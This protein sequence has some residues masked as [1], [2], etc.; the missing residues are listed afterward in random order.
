M[1]NPNGLF[2]VEACQIVR[3][4]AMSDRLS[5]VC[6]YGFELDQDNRN[7]TA[8]LLAQMI[9]FVVGGFAARLHEYPVDMDQMTAYLVDS[10][11]VDEPLTFYKSAKSDRWWIAIPKAISP[12]HQLVPCSYE[13]YQ[14]SCNGELPD[15]LINAISRL[16]S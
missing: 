5:S 15:R 2:A 1:M 6:L 7:Q 14:L 9:W 3:Y 13:D 11:D 4:M 10:S 12:Q 16:K 8:S